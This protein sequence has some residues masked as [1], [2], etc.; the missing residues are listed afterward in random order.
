MRNRT[1]LFVSENGSNLK[2]KR[3]R[4][5]KPS[6]TRWHRQAKTKGFSS[7]FRGMFYSSSGAVILEKGVSQLG[8][9]KPRLVT[10]FLC[11]AHV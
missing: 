9:T 1:K 4:D 5:R 2:S 8:A 7:T 6:S 10:G 3:E 11:T